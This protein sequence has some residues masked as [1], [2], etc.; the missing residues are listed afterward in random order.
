MVCRNWSVWRIAEVGQ[1]RGRE[2]RRRVKRQRKKE[3]EGL[4]GGDGSRNM[5]NSSVLIIDRSAEK[6]C[7]VAQTEMSN[8]GAAAKAEELTSETELQERPPRQ[9]N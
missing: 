3:E 9:K 4:R 6:I 8:V 2:E 7:I 5:K 1:L